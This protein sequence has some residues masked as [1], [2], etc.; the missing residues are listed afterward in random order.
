MSEVKEG[1]VVKVVGFVMYYGISYMKGAS[2][3]NEPA[4]M[5]LIQLE[6]CKLLSV[7]NPD[8]ADKNAREP[9]S[10]VTVKPASAQ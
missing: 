1:S 5:A 8:D 2:K 6:N 7:T 3:G 10:R 9:A 4:L